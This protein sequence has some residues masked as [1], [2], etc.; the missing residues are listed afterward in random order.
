[1]TRTMSPQ[2]LEAAI[3]EVGAE[4]YHDKHV[5]HRLLHGGK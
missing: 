5:F 4:R 3:R 1:M 2:E